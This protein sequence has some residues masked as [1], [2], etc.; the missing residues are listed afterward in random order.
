MKPIAN[1]SLEQHI[2]PYETWPLRT[3][4]DYDGVST[5]TKIPGY[6]LQH[7]FAVKQGYLL[8]TDWDCPFEEATSFILLNHDFRILSWRRL[9]LPYASF[10]L[11]QITLI[12]DKQLQ[13][14][15]FQD[16]HWLLTVR[17]WGLP[18]VYPRLKLQRLSA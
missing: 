13:L 15:F 3:R 16:D 8:I 12:D 14:T 7:Q 2:G 17:A 11:D 9:S 1:F 5:M 6:Q 18:F 10:L 4:L